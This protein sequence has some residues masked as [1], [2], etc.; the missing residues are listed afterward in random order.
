MEII[1]HGRFV[2]KEA[3]FTCK[4]CGCI[5]KADK[6]ECDSKSEEN[7]LKLIIGCPEC[8]AMCSVYIDS[9]K[10]LD[11]QDLRKMDGKIVWVVSKHPAIYPGKYTVKNLCQR[12]DVGKITVVDD[13]GI[14]L[15]PVIENIFYRHLLITSN[16][17]PTEF[18]IYEYRE[19]N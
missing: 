11:C 16:K 10:L 6:L 15:T 17:I 8:G 1:K 18:D 7:D 3:I 12:E 19:E 9:G 5:F 4:K 2:E 14:E 13:E